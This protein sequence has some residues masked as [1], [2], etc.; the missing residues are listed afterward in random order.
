MNSQA[1]L[2]NPILFALLSSRNKTKGIEWIWCV[3]FCLPKPLTHLSCRYLREVSCGKEL[4]K[5]YAQDLDNPSARIFMFLV[6]KE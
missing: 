5:N 6:Q 4:I 1:V 3:V 2:S